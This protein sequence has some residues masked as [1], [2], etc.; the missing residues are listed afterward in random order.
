MK[1]WIPW[2][3]LD[4]LLALAGGYVIY[5]PRA[6]VKIS[7][8]PSLQASKPH[9]RVFERKL[10][11]LQLSF[12]Y[13]LMRH[14]VHGTSYVSSVQPPV[15]SLRNPSDLPSHLLFTKQ[16][17]MKK[18]IKKQSDCVQTILQQRKSAENKPTR[19]FFPP[20]INQSRRIEPRHF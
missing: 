12:Y 18:V 10:V 1:F 20:R 5:S 9:L 15:L 19:P 4:F 8:K 13:P 14:F 6:A 17:I 11:L 7:H 16:T 2:G 3:K